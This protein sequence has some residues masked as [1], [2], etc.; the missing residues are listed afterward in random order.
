MLLGLDTYD[1]PA[2]RVDTVALTATK[3][4][5]VVEIEQQLNLGNIEHTLIG[6]ARGSSYLLSEPAGSSQFRPS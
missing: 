1:T 4:L 6:Q 3:Q 5:V 2:G